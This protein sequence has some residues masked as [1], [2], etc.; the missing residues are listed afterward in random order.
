MSTKLGTRAG[1]LG[2]LA[3][4]AV[5]LTGSAV[6]LAPASASAACGGAVGGGWLDGGSW[7]SVHLRS[8]SSCTMYTRLT[9]D[10]ATASIGHSWVIRV[11][12]QVNGTYG[13]LTSHTQSRSVIGG[14]Q[15]TRDTATVPNSTVDDDR[16]RA[17]YN[18]AGAGWVCTPW[19]EA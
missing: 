2:T 15:G 18:H 6:A 10:D 9:V 13:W 5:G 3:V 14:F 8:T 19:I 11:E 1:R 7:S 4:L 12:R 16:F 17:C